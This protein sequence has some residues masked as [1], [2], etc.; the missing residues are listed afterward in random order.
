M[1]EDYQ[2]EER[3]AEKRE[4]KVPIQITLPMA[5]VLAYLEHGLGEL[6]RK[7]GK[8]FIESVLESE[9]E[10]LMG[11]R[12]Q[13]NSGR[14]AYRW[15]TEQGYCVVDGQRVPIVRPRIRECGGGELPLGSYRLF[16]RASLVEETVWSN[17]IRGLSMRNY[18]EVLQQFADA[19]G[20]EK[21]TVSEHFIE[22][23]RNKP[24]ELMTRSL[25]HLQVCA[26]A[27]DG[28]IF[29]GQHLVVAIGIDSF[30]K[31]IVLGIIQGASENATVVS[32]LLD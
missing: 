30:G 18:K 22:A 19:Y 14:R 32:G 1:K 8:L 2:I 28:T 24:E 20:L 4:G 23:S 10:Q 3:P 26:L 31:K 7:V 17:V 6:V 12:L 25:A 16:Q 27:I 9:V 15:G 29:K 5:E 11:P 13:R 21:S